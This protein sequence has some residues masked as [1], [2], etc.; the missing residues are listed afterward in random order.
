MKGKY[1]ELARR[2]REKANQNAFL[3]AKYSN[4]DGKNLW[5]CI[6]SAMDWI[7]VG[8][9]YIE[10]SQPSGSHSLRNCMEIYSFLAAIDITYEAIISLFWV[11]QKN[12]DSSTR[13]RTPFYKDKG[14]FS[15]VT[16]WTISDDKFFKEIRACCGAHPT[17]LQTYISDDK[18]EKKQY[19]YACWT[20]SE[21]HSSFNIMLYPE[22]ATGETIVVE[23]L[24]A[25]LIDYF[26]Q[27]FNYLN[28]L[29]KR[30]DDLYD[31]Y[32]KEKKNETI[33]RSD[34][35]LE[36]L[37]F[38]KEANKQRLNNEYYDGVIDALIS[39]FSTNFE[40]KENAALINNYRSKLLLGFETLYHN[41]QHLD[42]QDMTLNE[43][44][45][46]PQINTEGFG[47]EFAALYTRVFVGS[48]KPLTLRVLTEPLKDIVCFDHVRT[49]EE[50]YWLIIIALNIRNESHQ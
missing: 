33:P 35:P 28:V 12:G 34:N 1:S 43:L 36:Q 27:R 10:E 16:N 41:I 39:F 21:T 32:K 24:Y 20:Y 5:N 45:H 2:F 15:A 17:D 25:E 18:S 30:I 23:I 50:L 14:C 31:E 22:K 6:C 9:Q 7:D 48:F 8:V 40:G 47:Y 42:Y 38:L 29:I 4:I 19:R 26:E 37:F 49:E 44:L 13:D 3:L 11:L 46:P